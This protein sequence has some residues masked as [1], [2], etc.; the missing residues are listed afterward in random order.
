MVNLT[1]AFEQLK[2]EERNLRNYIQILRQK[3]EYDQI[4]LKRKS[5]ALLTLFHQISNQETSPNATMSSYPSAPAA[6]LF[7]LMPAPCQS[8][9]SRSRMDAAQQQLITAVSTATTNTTTTNSRHAELDTF[10]GISGQYKTIDRIKQ[11]WTRVFPK[12][13]IKTSNNNAVPD[14]SD[15]Q[16]TEPRVK[17]AKGGKKLIVHTKDP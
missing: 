15:G 11:P 5:E 3:S 10:H 17:V 4:N 6:N 7:Q 8:H 13:F 16:L 14:K 9:H 2:L 12:S 1:Y